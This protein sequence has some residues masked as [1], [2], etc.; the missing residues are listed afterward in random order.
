[1]FKFNHFVRLISRGY[2]IN[3][4][5]SEGEGGVQRSNFRGITGVIGQRGEGGEKRVRK[6]R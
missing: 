2:S 4:V 1:M 3:D 5:N 6:L